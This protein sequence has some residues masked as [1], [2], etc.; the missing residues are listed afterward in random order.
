MLT[1]LHSLKKLY[2]A[3]MPDVG[4]RIYVAVTGEDLPFFWF[5][6]SAKDRKRYVAAEAQLPAA[7]RMQ[8]DKLV[9][10]AHHDSKRVQ[11]MSLTIRQDLS[12]HVPQA[13]ETTR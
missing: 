4:A 6:R 13:A 12:F 7:A 9:E 10:Q 11:T 3:S 8:I 1:D 2:A 5:V